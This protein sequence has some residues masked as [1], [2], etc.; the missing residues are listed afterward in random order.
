MSNTPKLSPFVWDTLRFDSIRTLR[1]NSIRTESRLAN[2]L[3]AWRINNRENNLCRFDW[4][5]KKQKHFQP[6]LHSPL[7]VKVRKIRTELRLANWLPGWRINNRENDSRWFD[8]IDSNRQHFQTTLHSPPEVKIR[9]IMIHEHSS[10][11]K[12]GTKLQWIRTICVDSIKSTWINNIFNPPYP[13]KSTQVQINSIFKSTEGET[14]CVDS[15]E[16]GSQIDFRF[17]ESQIPKTNRL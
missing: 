2:R 15:M 1:L 14:I 4:I 16:Q 6:N 9:E 11:L 12:C 3:P 5:N 10:F 8:R 7:E 17:V 13:P